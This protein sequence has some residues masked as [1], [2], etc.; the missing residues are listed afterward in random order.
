MIF[1]ILYIVT[2]RGEEYSL[3]NESLI[4]RKLIL[5]KLV[6]VIPNRIEIVQYKEVSTVDEIMKYFNLAIVNGEEGII[7]KKKNSLYKIDERSPDWIKI[8]SDY[9][10][11]IVD[12][13]D[14]LTIGGYFGD[15]KRSGKF[16]LEQN[17][18]DN[19]SSFLLG[20]L[21]NKTN[22]AKDGVVIPICKVGSGFSL[23]DLTLIRHKLKSNWK[24]YDV[25]SKSFGDWTP[26]MSER[27]DAVI[28]NISESILIELKAS[29]IVPSESFPSKMTFRFPRFIRIRSDKAWNDCMTIDEIS[30]FWTDSRKQLAAAIPLTPG[31][32]ITLA[33]LS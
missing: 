5:N 11:N 4:N 29:E 31:E 33:L 19:I 15:I 28:S 21:K 24:K 16:G 9:I 20:I 18:T 23:D 27:P 14:L 26:A 3:S 30:K 13:M 6:N 2:P 7:V 12:T 25:N 17:W 10:D 1:D 8:K 22:D 32:V